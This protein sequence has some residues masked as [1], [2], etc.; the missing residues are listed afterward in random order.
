MKQKENIF[1]YSTPKQKARDYKCPCGKAYLSYPAL[2]THVKQKHNG[3]VHHY[4]C[5]L[6]GI[7]KNLS[8]GIDQLKYFRKQIQM[9]L[10][11]LKIIKQ[12]CNAQIPG[13][14]SISNK[15]MSN[16]FTKTPFIGNSIIA[17]SPT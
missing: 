10:D 16:K 17:Y 7:L 3:K 5:R 15:K 12:R 4:L 13:A 1:D 11:S 9:A 14:T 8:N 2:F 6:L